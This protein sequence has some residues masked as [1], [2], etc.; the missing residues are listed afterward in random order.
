MR[1]GARWAWLSGLPTTVAASIGIGIIGAT[2]AIAIIHNIVHSNAQG[3]S[4]IG[5]KSVAAMV[6]GLAICGVHYTGMAA[7]RYATHPD[8]PLLA[9]ASSSRPVAARSPDRIADSRQRSSPT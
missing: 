9:G 4:R 6:M 7:A 2:A 5:F 3:P 8:A 1:P